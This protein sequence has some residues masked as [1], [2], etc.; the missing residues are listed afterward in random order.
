MRP[1]LALAIL[2]ALA[3]CGSPCQDLGDRI[4]GCRAPGVE[5]DQCNTAVK[6]QLSSGVQTPGKSDETH[7]QELLKTCPDPGNDPAMCDWLNTVPGKVACG[8]A[9]PQ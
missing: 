2:A 8:L 9:Y 6:N 1:V 7:C 3:A 5:R 4:C